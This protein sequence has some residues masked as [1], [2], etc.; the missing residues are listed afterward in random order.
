MNRVH[1][2]KS[3]SSGKVRFRYARVPQAQGE[4][5]IGELARIKEM[6]LSFTPSTTRDEMVK[7]K[8]YLKEI[9]IGKL[10]IKV[11]KNGK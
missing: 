6:K 11:V 7:V 5:S 1:V 2:R 3:I 4:Y 8:K 9:N 10:I